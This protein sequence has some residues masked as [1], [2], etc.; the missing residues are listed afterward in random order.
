[1]I[2]RTLIPGSRLLAWLLAVAFSV[3]LAGCKTDEAS[4]P[5]TADTNLTF[6]A[7]E[8]SILSLPAGMVP[9]GTS[10]TWSLDS[11]P[12]S[13]SPLP[14]IYPWSPDQAQF[15]PPVE[16][17]YRLTATV[18]HAGHVLR[19][20]VIV[21][22]TPQATIAFNVP[23]GALTT[24]T[25]PAAEVPAGTTAIS[26]DVVVAPEGSAYTIAA[27]GD[28][29]DFTPDKEGGYVLLVSMTVG[30]AVRR[31]VVHVAATGYAQVAPLSFDP[32]DARFSQFSDTLLLLDKA[33]PVLHAYSLATGTLS[34][35]ALPAVGNTLA[36]SENGLIAVVG[37]A[38]R[39]TR[40][41]LDTMTIASS[42]TTNRRY[43]SLAV[44]NAGVTVGVPEGSG[45][46]PLDTFNWTA[47]TVQ[48]SDSLA[49]AVAPASNVVPGSSPV[50]VAG[51]RFYVL[52]KSGDPVDLLRLEFVGGVA[53]VA[54]DSP[55]SGEFPIAGRLWSMEDID[56]LFTGAGSI[57]FARDTLVDDDLGYWGDLG[58][59][60]IEQRLVWT[61]FSAENGSA[62]VIRADASDSSGTVGVSEV[63]FHTKL[64]DPDDTVAMPLTF[65]GGRGYVSRAMWGF[66]SSDGSNHVIVTRARDT[67]Q[68]ANST[69]A[70]G[71]SIIVRN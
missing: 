17:E 7:Q 34:Q 4:A 44:D 30:D 37:Q 38:T 64:A 52:M 10:V 65:V 26:W 2:A 69:L 14:M 19:K 60:N 49:A 25:M 6:P 20:Q 32:V 55:F 61:D 67:A 21:T 59:D 54:Y 8:V 22:V 15:W 48:R 3:L 50:A 11:G 28:S 36:I 41:N 35:I 71:W 42:I 40:I 39:V 45:P 23:V 66:F 46:V 24:L 16:G 47:G 53:R 58:Q 13:W 57:F 62:I 68:L 56:Q 9:A 33:Q 70:G 12:V 29:T 1:M 43:A 31:R 51:G 18:R 63:D 5:P 27:N